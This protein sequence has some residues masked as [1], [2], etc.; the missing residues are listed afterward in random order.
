VRNIEINAQRY[1]AYKLARELSEQQLAA[2]EKK[3]SVGLSTKVFALDAQDKLST[4]RSLELKSL[5]DYNLSL[6]QYERATGTALASRNI[7]VSQFQ[8]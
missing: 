7:S 1:E 6:V 3:L 5:V 4:A 8:K 2:E